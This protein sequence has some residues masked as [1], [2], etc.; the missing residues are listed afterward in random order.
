[1][2]NCFN[3]FYNRNKNIFNEFIDIPKE[4]LKEVFESN[5]STIRI[6][7]NKFIDV[8]TN[9]EYDFFDA[10]NGYICFGPIESYLDI[11]TSHKSIKITKE[12]IKLVHVK[13]STLFIETYDYIN[14][15]IKVNIY[16]LEKIANDNSSLITNPAYIEFLLEAKNIYPKGEIN[17][18]DMSNYLNNIDKLLNKASLKSQNDEELLKNVFKLIKKLK[19]N[20][21]SNS[22]SGTIRKNNKIVDD[23]TLPI[24]SQVGFYKN[25]V[26]YF[27]SCNTNELLGIK[28]H[29]K[30]TK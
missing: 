26:A 17:F 16:G 6:I 12:A 23:I 19:I 1:M 3:E 8:L 4:I 18:Y 13:D 24:N 11:N 22:I 14:K 2:I 5:F 28:N 25:Y 10:T 9:I 29:S 7:N 30:Y 20:Y 27:N 15:R 21:N